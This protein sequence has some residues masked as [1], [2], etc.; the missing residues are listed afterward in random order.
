MPI[1]AGI[2]MMK[3]KR[4]GIPPILL[5]LL[6]LVIC[7][8]FILLSRPI[9]VR[10]DAA[11]YF[12]LAVNM[13]NG[14]GF[15]LDGVT[16]YAYRPPL[17]SSL[18]GAW[19]FATGHKTVLSAN[20]YQCVCVALSTYFAYYL[21]MEV[22][23]SRRIATAFTAILVV[24]PSLVTYTAFVLQE[25]TLLLFTTI[26]VW[27][28]LHWFVSGGKILSVLVGASWGIATLGKVVTV[29]ATPLLLLVW[30]FR[31]K[32][33]LHPRAGETWLVL[34]SF[35]IFMAPWAARNFQYFHRLILVND[36]ARGMLIW[37]VQQSDP[38]PLA[39]QEFPC[40]LIDVLKPKVPVGNVTRGEQFIREM[41]KE[42]RVPIDQ[43]R[44]LRQ[45]I[46]KNWRYFLALRIR[47]MVYF[48]L[49]GIDWWIH[50]GK[51]RSVYDSK[52]FMALLFLFQFPLY[53]FLGYRVFCA[54]RGKLDTQGYFLL[55]FYLSYWG[56][57]SL[58]WSDARFSI[59]VFPILLLF[60]PWEITGLQQEGSIS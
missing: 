20:L 42:T 1:G 6:S 38:P 10:D 21:A 27:L 25:P 12:R 13:A 9:P 52:I 57:Y 47:N 35:A 29:I 30:L 50:S 41:E 34:I 55:A 44:R 16:P 46:F 39:R 8:A 58:L 53:G 15:T 4:D 24:H 23:G 37:N 17:F 60:V 51:I 48:S 11:E 49:T 33:G 26:A 56:V 7:T 5:A 43:E 28:T 45:Y 59:P 3:A 54:A 40:L 36:Q 19:F 32:G 2:M 14:K 18:L 22:Y 31:R